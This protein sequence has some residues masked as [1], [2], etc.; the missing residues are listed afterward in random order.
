MTRLLGAGL[1]V[2]GSGAAGFWS[3][4]ERQGHTEAL[5][6]F[7]TYIRLVRRELQLTQADRG[8]LLAAA[9]RAL[10]AWSGFEGA[11]TRAQVERM[12]PPEAAE[13]C[14]R[15]YEGLG[16][17]LLEGQLQHCDRCAEEVAA[18]YE[19]GRRLQAD[20]RRLTLS[21]STLWGLLVA[22]LFY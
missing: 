16:K 6:E 22:I 3:S 10:P 21:L 4:L 12:L 7:C 8:E 11:P 5:G 17:S 20:R 9:A 1:I 13:V 14:R 2:L 19:E 18:L 15:F